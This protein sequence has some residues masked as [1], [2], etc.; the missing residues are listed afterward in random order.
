MK[1]EFKSFVKSKPELINYINDGTM[2]WQKFYELWSLYGSD[3]KIWNNYIKK[4]N[5]IGD[6]NLSSIINS[7]KNID[8]DSVKKGVT[9]I[10][11]VIEIIQGFTTKDTLSNVKEGYEPR[12]LFKKFED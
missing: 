4:D 1:E 2:T 7:I 9:N 11:K 6:F 5:L 10:Q 3:D 12:Q 8:M